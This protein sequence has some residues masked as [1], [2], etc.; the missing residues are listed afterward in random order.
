M[1]TE[2]PAAPGLEVVDFG[3]DEEEEVVLPVDAGVEDEEE[4]VT[5]SAFACKFLFLFILRCNGW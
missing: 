5:P 4:S 3:A 2:R 1:E